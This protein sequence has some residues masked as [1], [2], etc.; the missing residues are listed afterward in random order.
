M[1]TDRLIAQL[2][3][4]LSP[5]QPLRRPG[6]RAFVWLCGASAFLGVLAISMTSQAD[7]AANGGGIAF[8]GPQF[9]AILTAV[10]AARAA[11]TS[12]IPGYSRAPLIWPVVAGL[13]WVA[14]L[15]IGIP[16]GQSAAMLAAPREWM[17]VA[18]IVLSGG[19]MM[20][21]LWLMLRQGAPLNPSVTAALGALAVGA[22]A[23][24]AACV[25]HPHT[26]N[27][28][29]LVWHGATMAVLVALASATGHLALKLNVGGSPAPE[30]PK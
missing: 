26:N 6:F 27:G 1:N 29:T 15:A 5:V 4:R 24:V 10:L 12:V 8:V 2:A 19:P 14:A 9:I 13:V 22:L 21:A 28:I 18:V 17:C 30:I 16:A 11:F 7:V 25:A 20:V 3:D 23:N